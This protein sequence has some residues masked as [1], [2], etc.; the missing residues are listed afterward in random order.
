MRADRLLSIL[1]L[2]QSR[3][4]MTAR[5]LAEEL[6]VSPRTIYRDIDALGV[7]GVPVY[8]ESGPDGGF[9]LLDSYRTN[10]T[11]LS[12]DEVRALFMLN[13]P[14][15]LDALGMAEDLKAAMRKLAA[16]VSRVYQR[17]EARVRQRLY[18]DAVW[19]HHQDGGGPR[20]RT[21]HEAVWQDRCV[22]IR[23]HMPP[24]GQEMVQRVA[25]Y[26]LVAK[27]GLWHLV[28]AVAEG[29]R[30]VRV[31]SLTGVQ[32]T[33][34][35]FE[36]SDTFDLVSFWRSWC[37]QREAARTFYTVTVLLAPR[38][39]DGF[40]YAL[41]EYLT[42]DVEEVRDDK[43]VGG[44]KE[45]GKAGWYRA[46]LAFE[47]LEEARQQLLALGGG[48]E[49]LTPVALRWSMQDYACQ[50]LRAYDGGRADDDRDFR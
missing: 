7:A 16:S 33:M 17:D 20:L 34:E 5:A 47:S 40:P 14:G 49:V 18:I 3:G 28:Y 26:A 38:L 48:V 12:A 19:W 43:E 37:E 30:V 41:S 32:A 22:E 24:L 4:R 39:M 46:T 2:L 8:G 44:E 50:I 10:L 27:G 31:R 21:L 29:M 36:R 15:P 42:G 35:P 9:A 25:P 1:M 23:Y 13:I 6:E 45:A 11:G